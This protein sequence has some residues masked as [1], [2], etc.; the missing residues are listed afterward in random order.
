MLK[1]GKDFNLNPPHSLPI[2]LSDYD[3]KHQKT[4]DEITKLFNTNFTREFITRRMQELIQKEYG[5]P[6]VKDLFVVFLKSQGE[7]I[8]ASD[9]DFSSN[10]SVE[11]FLKRFS[12][13]PIASVTMLI[14]C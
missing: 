8:I 9:G 1:V 2:R 3:K 14:C 6:V 13:D 10:T 4:P 11:L 5:D 7:T 12:T